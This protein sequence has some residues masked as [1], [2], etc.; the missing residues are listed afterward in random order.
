MQIPLIFGKYV[1]VY[2]EN[3][4]GNLANKKLNTI[5]PFTQLML[6]PKIYISENE[7]LPTSWPFLC[8]QY[9]Y[10]CHLYTKCFLDMQR[11]AIPQN[12]YVK[13]DRSILTILL[14]FHFWFDIGV[15][16]FHSKSI[17]TKKTLEIIVFAEFLFLGNETY[18]SH[19]PKRHYQQI[20]LTVPVLT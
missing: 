12:Y 2:I 5:I 13:H 18:M 11:L 4:L 9:I 14:Y 7:N 19:V 17:R 8:Y 10:F 3:L 16:G 6:R 15:A 1:F 20:K